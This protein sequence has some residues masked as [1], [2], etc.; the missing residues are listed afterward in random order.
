MQG[1]SRAFCSATAVPRLRRCK[2]I[3]FFV[4]LHF[5][6]G[7]RQRGNQPGTIRGGTGVVNVY[8]IH[9]VA[10]IV[11]PVFWRHPLHKIT[12]ILIWLTKRGNM[13]AEGWEYPYQFLNFVK[14]QRNRL[15]D[16]RDGGNGRIPAVHCSKTILGKHKR[17]ARLRRRVTVAL[18]IADVNRTLYP[19]AL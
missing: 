2:I 11:M 1:I 13:Y 15:W 8:R 4:R 3:D 18:G 9:M 12:S 19:V 7:L 10:Y 5:K 17:D 6:L 14:Q 16:F